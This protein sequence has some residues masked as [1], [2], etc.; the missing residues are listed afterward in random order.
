MSGMDDLVAWLRNRIGDD[1]EMAQVADAL[2]RPPWVSQVTRDASDYNEGK[3]VDG[4]G[5]AVVH[6]EDQTP[7]RAVAE[8]IARWDPARVL[9]ELDAKR[10]ILDEHERTECQGHAEPWVEHGAACRYRCWV[11]GGDRYP[12]ATLRLLAVPYADQPGY[13]DEWR[14]G[15]PA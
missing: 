13:R 6:V 9:A 11:C 7:E 14:P 2:T 12:C 10:R 8:H 4:D 15:V 1:Y 5:L 3:I